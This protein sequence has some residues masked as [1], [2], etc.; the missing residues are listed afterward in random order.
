MR[1]ARALLLLGL[2]AAAGCEA[3]GDGEAARGGTVVIA[4]GND[5]Q[6]FNSLVEPESY[7]GEFMQYALFL[8][9]IRYDEELEYAPGLAR[10]WEWQGD[11]AVVF[12]LHQ[13][14]RWHDGRPTTA[15]D[16]AFTI[17]R[18]RDPATG[19]PN[20]QYFEAWGAV[21]A[22]DSF[23]VRVAFP[24]HADPLAGLPFTP[25]MPRHLLDSI[26][27]E[28]MQNAAFNQRP[29]GNGPFRFL[30]RRTNDR[31]VFEANRD[32][33]EE[34]GGPPLIDRIIWRVIPENSAQV[35]ALRTGEVDVAHEIR[36]DQ[37]VALD[38]MPR[39]RAIVAPSRQYQFI[40]WN[41]R[42]PQL[43]DAR[44]RRALTMALD[45]ES[46]LRALRGGFGE[47]TST[48]VSP[49]HWAHRADLEP[50]PYDTAGARALL[51]E[52]GYANRDRD[53]W[54][55]DAGGKELTI[56]LQI[57]ANSEYNRD[58]AEIIRGDLQ[59]VGVRVT[60]A[61]TE[62][63][64]LIDNI[65]SPPRNFEAVLLALEADIR[66]SLREVFH[67]ESIPDSPFQ[68]AGY[69]NPRLDGILDSLD[70][71]V[72]RDH[73]RPL[74]HRLQT[75]LHEEQPW[76]F[77]WF[78]P[79]IVVVREDLNGVEMDLRGSLVS[80]QDW[81]LDPSHPRAPGGGADTATAAATTAATSDAPR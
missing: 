23:T 70:V 54:L 56:E 45:R 33:P 61:A 65:S 44:V 15:E 27:A 51:D 75:I 50:I 19:F 81:W 58:L 39:F 72:S 35:V 5:L 6:S 47:L 29:V 69:A 32:F 7:T 57:P 17:D 66:L 42:V 9:L 38:T 21:E 53:P 43:R 24:P 79:R 8:P 52:A 68:L 48:P 34:L 18:A 20:I 14:V 49:S 62:F 3:S 77:L 13:N 22:L 37:G 2:L 67:S 4:G 12:R 71:T 74:W 16:V 78:A 55:E 1:H 64:T 60:T 25:I 40:G 63:G 11:T 28:R 36:A 80:I 73:A 76:S 10:E 26:P 41:N 59:D 46:M 31:V 30:S